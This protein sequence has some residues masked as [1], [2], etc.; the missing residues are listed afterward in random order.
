MDYNFFP[1]MAAGLTLGFSAGVSPGP[2]LALTISETL[3]FG[4]KTGIKVALTPLVTDAP[5]IIGTVFLL[6]ELKELD[7]IFALISIVGALFLVYFGFENLFVK[8]VA[9]EIEGSK[10]SSFQK[11]ILANYLNPHPYL[12][13]MTI[14]GP[15][16]IGGL[17]IS[18]WNAAVYIITFYSMLVGSKIGVVIVSSRMS[19]FLKSNKYLYLIRGAG[20]MLLVLAVILFI[21]GFVK[22]QL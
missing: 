20:L 11:A 1:M 9:G 18:P 8:S 7:N 3:K 15:L 6:S 5:I 17:E 19:A 16:F 12:F 22:L 2:L 4:T 14:G 21:D 10:I 13:W